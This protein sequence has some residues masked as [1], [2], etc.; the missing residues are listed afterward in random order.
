MALPT[1]FDADL[2]QIMID[3]T[4]PG[5]VYD[6]VMT[7]INDRFIEYGLTNQERATVMAQ[8]GTVAIQSLSTA[9]I[10]AIM[11]KYQVDETRNAQKDAMDPAINKLEKYKIDQ[12]V[13][14]DQQK[15]DNQTKLNDEQVRL[16]KR[17][18]R[19]YDDNMLIKVM[20]Q[21]AQNVSYALSV[22]SGKIQET[23][24]KMNAATTTI[25]GRIC[26]VGC[27]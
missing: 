22:D 27:P 16:V 19:G 13:N 3:L 25:E 23:I 20:E 10:S 4:G 18:T 26:N 9:G 8:L 11:Q 14:L 6:K 24:N 1:G 7:D 5:S 12:N 15:I 17:Q 21:R 2:K